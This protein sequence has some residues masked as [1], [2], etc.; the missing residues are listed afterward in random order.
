MD[1]L[2]NIYPITF[3]GDKS[4][5]GSESIDNIIAALSKENLEQV[6]KYI[7]DWNTNAKNYRT[8]QTILHAIVKSFSSQDLLEING[9]KDVSKIIS[10]LS[11]FLET[12][13]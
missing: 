10:N 1:I 5:T 9:I 6:L 2:K 3:L 13:D 8:S 12:K 7:R 11:L 4:I